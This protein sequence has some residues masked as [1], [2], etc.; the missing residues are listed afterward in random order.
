MSIWLPVFIVCH[1]YF[2]VSIFFFDVKDFV[3]F[4]LEGAIEI[5]IT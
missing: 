4:A 3:M 2:D 5:Q 1:F